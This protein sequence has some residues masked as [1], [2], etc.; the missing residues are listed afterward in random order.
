M[1]DPSQ[2]RGREQALSPE[3]LIPVMVEVVVL[4]TIMMNLEEIV[5]VVL[6]V[7]VY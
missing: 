6:V 1:L 5:M 7:Q 3:H 2:L 4:I